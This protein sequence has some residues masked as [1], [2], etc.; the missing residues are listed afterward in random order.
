M[1]RSTVKTMKLYKNM[2]KTIRYAHKTYSV[3]VQIR[4][5]LTIITG[6]TSGKILFEL[7]ESWKCI[8]EL[9]ISEIGLKLGLTGVLILLI[10]ITL[11]K[12]HLLLELL[13]ILG[14][15]EMGLLLNSMLWKVPDVKGELLKTSWLTIKKHC[16]ELDK[17]KWIES[18]REKVLSTLPQKNWEALKG[19]LD[20]EKITS[21]WDT[22]TE[23]TSKLELIK[24]S[25]IISQ[26][27][28]PWY[29]II[30][31]NP[32]T[33][34][35]IVVALIGAI[36]YLAT[37]VQTTKN[38]WEGLKNLAEAHVANVD[39]WAQIRK[40][41]DITL[42]VLKRVQ[43]S[44]ATKIDQTEIHKL[45][46]IL[47]ENNEKLN[48]LS[49]GSLSDKLKLEHEVKLLKSLTGDIFNLLTNMLK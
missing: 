1:S 15:A 44:L 49:V 8:T 6:I 27:H 35:L 32:K 47:H 30:V 45:I 48:S 14:L 7:W 29:S 12:R 17:D 3:I 19:C 26:Q 21:Y 42:N 22:V 43:E 46:S 40:Q 10:G 23:M 25:I 38:M 41:E 31:E 33:S 9:D 34:L 37:Q 16:T 24:N 11:K 2:I 18:I 13:K 39:M 20:K 36:Y 4:R 5:V 28:R